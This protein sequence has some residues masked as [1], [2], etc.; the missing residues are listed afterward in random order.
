MVGQ[1]SRSNNSE[2]TKDCNTGSEDDSNRRRAEVE[3]T[4]VEFRNPGAAC[5]GR[6]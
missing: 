6:K 2:T 1:P 4:L 5:V 3:T